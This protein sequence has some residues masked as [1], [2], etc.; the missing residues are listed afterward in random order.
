MF[1]RQDKKMVGRDGTGFPG[2][3]EPGNRLQGK[4]TD[5]RVNMKTVNAFFKENKA[6]IA[7]WTKDQL[8]DVAQTAAKHHLVCGNTEG[9]GPVLWF[10][11][12]ELGWEWVKEAGDLCIDIA[13][14][15]PEYKFLCTSNFTHPHF[16][17]IWEDVKWHRKITE[18]IRRN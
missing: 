4:D 6:G 2:I 13:V 15:F 9:W 12:P 14:G 5:Y 18:R 10:D 11:H 17:G 8:T 16:K 7:V 1:R 3:D